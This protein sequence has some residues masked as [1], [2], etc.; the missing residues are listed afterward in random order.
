MPDAREAVVTAGAAAASHLRLGHPDRA[1]GRVVDHA[2]ALLDARADGRARH[3]H[4][5]VVVDLDPVVVL[6]AD[7]GRVLVVQPARLDP[8]RE[9]RHAQRVAVG[10]VDVPLAVRRQV[11]EDE[12]LALLERADREV[13]ELLAE[14][15]LVAGQVLPEVDV[16]RDGRRRG[17]GGRS[18]CAT[19]RAARRSASTPRRGDRRS[20]FRS[21]PGS[22]A[23]GAAGSSARRTS[24]ARRGSPRRGR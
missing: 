11:V 14:L 23:S 24:S 15:R 19:G 6:H 18:A 1:L 20:R 13:A 12:A 7:R 8:A 4:A 10:R 3:H 16:E 21:R 9:R 22:S 5:V 17:A 2:S